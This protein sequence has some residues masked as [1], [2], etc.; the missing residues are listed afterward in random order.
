MTGQR[1]GH[2]QPGW[3]GVVPSLHG[4]FYVGSL[5]GVEELLYICGVRGGAES[6]TWSLRNR[7]R[8]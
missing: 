7:G 2:G 6:I 3:E 1:T 4:V 5:R 8:A